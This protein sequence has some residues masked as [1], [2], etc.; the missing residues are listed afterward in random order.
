MIQLGFCIIHAENG[1]KPEGLS[2]NPSQFLGD[3]NF[4]QFSSEEKIMFMAR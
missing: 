4:A 2:L 1:V 3:R